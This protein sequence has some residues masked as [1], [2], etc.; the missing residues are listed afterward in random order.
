[1][2]VGFFVNGSSIMVQLALDDAARAVTVRDH[3]AKWAP[4]EFAISHKGS[5]MTVLRTFE[6]EQDAIDSARR[7]A[8]GWMRDP[9]STWTSAARAKVFATAR[10]VGCSD[11]IS[12]PIITLL[13]GIDLGLRPT[14]PRGLPPNAR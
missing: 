14:T 10:R 6:T 1:M 3:I 4:D 11:L 2:H 9:Y 7:S 12:S 5:T 13:L 8:G